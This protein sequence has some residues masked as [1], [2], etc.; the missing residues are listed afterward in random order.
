MCHP[1]LAWDRLSPSGR[2]A[3]AMGYATLSYFTA[4]VVLIALR[5]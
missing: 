2:V 1:S 4:L 5:G 3:L